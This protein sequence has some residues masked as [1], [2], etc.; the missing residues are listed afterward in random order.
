MYSL[1]M[2]KQCPTLPSTANTNQKNIHPSIPSRKAIS[3]AFQQLEGSDSQAKMWRHLTPN[4]TSALGG[5]MPPPQSAARISLGARAQAVV[6]CRW[7]L[8]EGL[9]L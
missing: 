9:L 8:F 3:R 6:L 4:S 5:P 1:L 2:I 7:F